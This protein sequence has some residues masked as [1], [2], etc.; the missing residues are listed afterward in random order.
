MHTAIRTILESVNQ[1][2]SEEVKHYL[3]DFDGSR[4]A[5]K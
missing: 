5:L 2:E 4:G 3:R 1:R